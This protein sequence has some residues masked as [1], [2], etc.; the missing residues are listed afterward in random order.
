MLRNGQSI[1]SSFHLGMALLSV[2]EIFEII[3]SP[4]LSTPQEEQVGIKINRLQVQ[5]LITK[6]AIEASRA[7]RPWWRFC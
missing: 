5:T 3:F 4:F 2:T 6:K 1:T 7:K